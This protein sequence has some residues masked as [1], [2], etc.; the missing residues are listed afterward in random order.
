MVKY[1]NLD[2]LMF[3]NFDEIM[4][5]ITKFNIYNRTANKILYQEVLEN[6]TNLTENVDPILDNSNIY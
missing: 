6:I 2:Y 3:I 4:K 1:T 5:E